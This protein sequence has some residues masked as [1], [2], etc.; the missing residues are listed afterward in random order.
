[1][2][3][4]FPELPA[5]FLWKQ[6]LKM[7][8]SLVLRLKCSYHKAWADT[9][10]CLL[11]W[12]I[13]HLVPYGVIFM[14]VF[15]F[16]LHSL[17]KHFSLNVS[18]LSKLKKK[19]IVCFQLFLAYFCIYYFV[20]SFICV[21]FYCNFFYFFRS[22]AS[23][24]AHTFPLNHRSHLLSPRPSAVCHCGP[25]T[26]SSF[27]PYSCCCFPTTPPTLFC[28]FSQ[29]NHHFLNSLWKFDPLSST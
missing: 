11:S 29:L 26:L 5:L 17:M 15:F 22:F 14:N 21:F 3:S 13:Q 18:N 16:F 4:S 24:H 6:E 7:V 12:W 23:P 19:C 28:I 27:P 2:Y 1:M 8:L 20:Y 25:F 9:N 10:N